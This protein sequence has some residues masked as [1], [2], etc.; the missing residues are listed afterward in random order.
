MP[1]VKDIPIK[2]RD[3][4]TIG[5]TCQCEE[6]RVWDPVP[7]L[8]RQINQDVFK[9]LEGYRQDKV[10][11][12][13]AKQYVDP[14][15]VRENAAQLDQPSVL[16]DISQLLNTQLDKETLATCVHMIESGVNPEALA[17]SSSSCSKG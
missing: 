17:V 11:A 14:G 2:R 12:A 9:Q 16:Y 7:G 6:A 13:D 1:E 8:F 15:Y 5:V 3:K 10:S 4:S